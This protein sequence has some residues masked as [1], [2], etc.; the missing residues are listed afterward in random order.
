MESTEREFRALL[1][2]SQND[3]DYYAQ[4]LALDISLRI[5]RELK[6]L[7]MTRKAFGEKI[8]VS[9]GRVTQML[10]GDSNLTL[11]S[12][13]RLALG[14]GLRPAI[15]FS[16]FAGIN[17][18]ATP[19]VSESSNERE[20]TMARADEVALAHCVEMILRP[21]VTVGRQTAEEPDKSS[22]PDFALAG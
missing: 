11:L 18:S 6:N 17:V 16:S 4:K 9:G 1:E 3:P 13:C 15:A 10:S 5:S 20:M 14:V 19:A 22:L 12:L 8:E 7:G 2:N 21:R